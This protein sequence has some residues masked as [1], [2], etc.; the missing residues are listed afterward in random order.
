ML[1]PKWEGHHS[2]PVHRSSIIG[3]T[4]KAG[5]VLHGK[6]DA[7]KLSNAAFYAALTFPTV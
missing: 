3:H 2:L 7:G 4:K 5:R 6:Q 1:S